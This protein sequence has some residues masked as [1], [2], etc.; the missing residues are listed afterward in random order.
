[1]DTDDALSSHPN[2][3]KPPKELL[4]FIQTPIP[5]LTLILSLSLIILILIF[6]PLLQQCTPLT[7]NHRHSIPIISSQIVTALFENRV[8]EREILR[9]KYASNGVTL[10]IVRDVDV[11]NN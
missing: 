10:H 2:S 1:M 3:Y 9:A 6:Y 11:L 8:L 4:T 7:L 5:I